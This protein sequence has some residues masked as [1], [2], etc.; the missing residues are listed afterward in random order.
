MRRTLSCDKAGKLLL[1]QI[2][3]ND[4]EIAITGT[5]AASPKEDTDKKKTTIQGR[6]I[7]GNTRDR[8]LAKVSDSVRDIPRLTLPAIPMRNG[9][10]NNEERKRRRRIH[11]YDFSL[12]V[13]RVMP[14]R[15]QTRKSSTSTASSHSSDAPAKRLPYV[16]YD[17]NYGEYRQGEKSDL[18]DNRN[19][20]P[21]SFGIL[22]GQRMCL[23]RKEQ[24]N[25]QQK[26]YKPAEKERR[27]KH[28]G[29][30]LIWFF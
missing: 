29:Q 27:K 22:E 12:Q 6:L 8:M 24:L 3:G 7:R 14:E 23:L 15:N 20:L 10:V 30:P 19:L 26:R 1:P 17:Q 28:K 25:K 16:I 18:R 21:L 2:F 5:N 13:Q 9:P 11:C 4:P